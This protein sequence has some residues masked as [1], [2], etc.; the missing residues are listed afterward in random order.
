[1]LFYFG[2][3]TV[4]FL[5]TPSPTPAVCLRN[6]T[7]RQRRH[8]KSSVYPPR[9]RRIVSYFYQFYIIFIFEIQTSFLSLELL[10]VVIF[11]ELHT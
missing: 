4:V 5:L 6:V 3:M 10:K 1:M 9:N 11:Q 2:H 8:V 7:L